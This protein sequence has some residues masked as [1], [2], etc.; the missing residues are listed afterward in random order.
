MQ[1]AGQQSTPQ[2]LRMTL[3]SEDGSSVYA[4][5]RLA[6]G[7]PGW[8]R[9]E[10]LLTAD[11]SDARAKLGISFEGPGTLLL[12]AV[13][14]WPAENLRPGQ[15]NPWPFRAD[16]LRMLAALRPRCMPPTSTIVPFAA[17]LSWCI[18]GWCD[19]WEFPTAEG[20]QSQWP[21]AGS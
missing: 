5:A 14:L 2:W 17:H 20:L 7:A 3:Q 8:Q 4:S 1:A 15:L 12:G 18:Y 13:S 6:L 9:M 11:G 21:H 10:A 16:L 19:I